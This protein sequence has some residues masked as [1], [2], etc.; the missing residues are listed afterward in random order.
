MLR[1]FLLHPRDQVILRYIEI[2]RSRSRRRS[3]GEERTKEKK[4]NKKK[5]KRKQRRGEEEDV[6]SE[7]DHHGIITQT[8]KSTRGSGR[9]RL[10]LD[11]LGQPSTDSDRTD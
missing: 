6:S 11:G 9:R 3:R 8:C 10:S 5:K 2:I 1:V 7:E 4:Q